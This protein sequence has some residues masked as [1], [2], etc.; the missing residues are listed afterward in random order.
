MVVAPSS[1]EHA[2][3]ST[4]M[5]QMHSLE[6]LWKHTVPTD[7]KPPIIGCGELSQPGYSVPHLR[8]PGAFDG[9]R[10]PA[11]PANWYHDAPARLSPPIGFS[12]LTPSIKS[13]W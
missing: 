13:Q 11:A 3:T 1:Y 5:F 7:G 4:A 6:S 12:P 10:M 8:G 2:H 9:M